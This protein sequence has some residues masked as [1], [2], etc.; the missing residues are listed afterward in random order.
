MGRMHQKSARSC[1]ESV[2]ATTV[3]KGEWEPK[4]VLQAVEET[5]RFS[6]V[7]SARVADL[8]Q[9][10]REVAVA[11]AVYIWQFAGADVYLHRWDQKLRNCQEGVSAFSHL[12]EVVLR[13]TCSDVHVALLLLPD[14]RLPSE[15]LAAVL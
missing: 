8:V 13:F 11:I 1:L 4:G 12:H 6:W 10:H 14:G 2:R 3:A 15:M 5:P 7:Q 9:R